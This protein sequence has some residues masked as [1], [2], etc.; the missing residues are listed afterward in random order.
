MAKEQMS[1]EAIDNLLDM[2]K[3][4]NL[5]DMK[6]DSS[7]YSKF[8]CLKCRGILKVAGAD[9]AKFIKFSNKGRVCAHWA[10]NYDHIKI[11]KGR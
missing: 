2:L 7:I 4:S 5:N 6:M 9:S 1:Q 8:I 11:K 3:T 10:V